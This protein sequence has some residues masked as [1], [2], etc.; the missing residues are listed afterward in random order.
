MKSPHS[1]LSAQITARTTLDDPRGNS[2]NK[3][4]RVTLSD[5]RTLILKTVSREWDWIARATND[6]GRIVKLWENGAFDRMPPSIDHTILGVEREDG[7]WRIFM[8]DAA[9]SLLRD[10]I[11]HD[12]RTARRILEAAKD[13]HAAFWEA[14]LPGLCSIEDRY[15][16]LSPDTA[17][18]EKES[19]DAGVADLIERSWAAFYENAPSDVAEI[20]RRLADDPTPIADEL[21]SCRQTLIHGDLRIGN[22]GFDGDR[23]IL[24]DWGERAGIAPPAVELAWFIGFD[25]KRLD[26]TRDEI[27]E[28]FR[29]LYGERFE[30]R[31]LQLALIGGLVHL[32]AHIGLG[33]VSADDD[34][35]LGAAKEDC[36]WWT[37]RVAQALEVWSAA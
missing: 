25:A 31:A 32:G 2:G 11:R 14:D 27:V 18:R 22:V 7:S 28:A 9:E 36:A 13:L 37:R 1:D 6:D 24:L 34:S 5:G 21:R 17:R 12:G 23:T 16:M 4:E 26:I 20:I 33:F 29:E 15:R 35:K 8:R 30:E 19:G 10:D 3:I